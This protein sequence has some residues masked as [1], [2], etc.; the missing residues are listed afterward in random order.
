[1]SIIEVA[2]AEYMSRGN[3]VH[4]KGDYF[5]LPFRVGTGGVDETRPFSFVHTEQ[6]HFSGV[7]C[8]RPTH[9]RWNHS[10]GQPPSLSQAIIWKATFSHRKSQY[11]K[12]TNISIALLLTEAIQGFVFRLIIHF[13]FLLSFCFHLGVILFDKWNLD[14][15]RKSGLLL[16]MNNRSS[17]CRRC[18]AVFSGGR[19]WG[20]FNRGCGRQTTF[21]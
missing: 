15:S 18:R 17:R 7:G 20:Y 4:W 16:N 19:G 14:L 3:D 21:Y 9:A 5:F 6:Y 1:M 8:L 11:K 10:N 2:G 13:A 12:V